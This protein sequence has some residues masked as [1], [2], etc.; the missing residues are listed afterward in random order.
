MQP[1]FQ[2]VLKSFLLWSEWIILN[3][4]NIIKD[5][6]TS[7][8]SLTLHAVNVFVWNKILSFTLFKIIT[9]IRPSTL[10]RMFL[11]GG[12]GF[13]TKGRTGE[14]SPHSCPKFWVSPFYWMSLPTIN[15]ALHSFLFA[16]LRP[17]LDCW[18]HIGKKYL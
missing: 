6:A 8:P 18:P 1:K 4:L 13:A 9:V 11:M 12:S 16:P 2:K 15:W 5:F 17:S 10:L 7:F 14:G 3:R